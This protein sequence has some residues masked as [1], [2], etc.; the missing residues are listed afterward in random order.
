MT[1]KKLMD[2]TEFT[3]ASGQFLALEEGTVLSV[4]PAMDALLYRHNNALEWGQKMK[5]YITDLNERF[6]HNH[7]VMDD[8]GMECL[9]SAFSS[10][11]DED[12]SEE[13]RPGKICVVER[14][15]ITNPTL[16]LATLVGINAPLAIGYLQPDR[17]RI[18]GFGF[19]FDYLKEK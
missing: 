12:D 7:K 8:D 18:I 9:V 19:E 10:P 11:F 17:W 14:P 15:W 1:I 16:E 6:E 3:E 2:L 5:P 4:S 13:M